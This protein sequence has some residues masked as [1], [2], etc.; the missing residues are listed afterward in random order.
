MFLIRYTKNELIHGKVKNLFLASASSQSN[1]KWENSS[2][3][4]IYSNL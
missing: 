2:R 4:I 1:A 3:K